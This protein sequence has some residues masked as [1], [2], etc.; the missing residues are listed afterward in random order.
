MNLTSDELC[1]AWRSTHRR[2]Q[3][4]H[5]APE[6][7]AY[8]RLRRTVLEELERRHPREVAAW[9]SAG[10]SAEQSPTVLSRGRGSGSAPEGSP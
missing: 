2:L 6:V 4:A 10:G 1:Q 8:A 7:A 9:L 5:T 3:F